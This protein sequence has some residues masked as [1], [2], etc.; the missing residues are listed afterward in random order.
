MLANM[1]IRL[2]GGRKW[3]NEE[4]GESNKRGRECMEEIRLGIWDL[5]SRTLGV[6]FKQKF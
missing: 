2:N 3:A 6:K 4:E 1:F 5:E